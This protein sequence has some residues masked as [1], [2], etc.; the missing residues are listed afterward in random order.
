MNINFYNNIIE[1]IDIH[2]SYDNFKIVNLLVYIIPPSVINYN[3]KNYE[4]VVLK[5]I[6]DT[7][8]F[9]M[10]S[11]YNINI[12]E[13]DK[14]FIIT[15]DAYNIYNINDSICSVDGYLYNKHT[16]Q[17]LLINILEPI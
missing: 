9:N 4:T 10:I 15:D 12:I 2:V 11:R 6:N 3:K 13:N 16:I 14:N 8:N 1:L 5:F 17:S 7:N